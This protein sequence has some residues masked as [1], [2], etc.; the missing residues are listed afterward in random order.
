VLFV[1]D[2]CEVWLLIA[3]QDTCM[4][5]P[6]FEMCGTWSLLVVL[7]TLMTL[8]GPLS[9]LRACPLPSCLTSSRHVLLWEHLAFLCSGGPQ[10]LEGVSAAGGLGWLFSAPHFVMCIGG[11]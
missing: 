1:W 7:G 9:V 11:I 6:G 8:V 2:L 5:H 4:S 3:L 10:P